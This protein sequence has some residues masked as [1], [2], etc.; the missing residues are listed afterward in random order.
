MI[1]FPTTKPTSKEVGFCFFRGKMSPCR[2]Q[3]RLVTFQVI[4]CNSPQANCIF[5]TL[6]AKAYR[7]LTAPTIRRFR[8]S[9]YFLINNVDS[10]AQ[11]AV[12]QNDIPSPGFINKV[13]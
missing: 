3:N 2:L 4:V 13:D 11:K 1:R 7:I 12:C 9:P 8:I 6:Y 10:L 5:G